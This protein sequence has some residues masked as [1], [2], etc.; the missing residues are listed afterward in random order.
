[1]NCVRISISSLNKKLL[2]G[3]T[4]VINDEIVRLPSHF[5]YVWDILEPLIALNLNYINQ[6]YLKL[7]KSRQ[8]IYATSDFLIKELN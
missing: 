2:K 1:M 8:I 6:N 3:I 4:N 5:K 7:L